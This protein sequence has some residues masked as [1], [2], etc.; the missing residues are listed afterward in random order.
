MIRICQHPDCEETFPVLATRGQP[1]LYCP[2]H[3]STRFAMIRNRKHPELKAGRV[4]KYPCCQEAGRKCPQH[5]SIPKHHMAYRPSAS[6]RA[7]IGELLDVFG[8]VS[9][10]NRGYVQARAFAE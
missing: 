6:D 10:W 4:P 2:G 8:H 5:R 9:I 1:P 7:A 3:R